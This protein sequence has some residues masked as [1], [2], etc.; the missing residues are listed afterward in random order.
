[1]STLIIN[2]DEFISYSKKNE[3]RILPKELLKYIKPS[4][5]SVDITVR[6]LLNK[7]SESNYDTILGELLS[8]DLDSITTKL[9]DLVF[10]KS[11]SEKKY[12]VLYGRLCS[13]LTGVDNFRSVLL[14]KIQEVFEKI[15]ENKLVELFMSKDQII[16]F[17]TF[18]GELYNG[19][20]ISESITM[21]IVETLVDKH[22]KIVSHPIENICVLM[23][24]IRNKFK[25]YKL[26]VKKLKV[27]K[28][29]DQ[30]SIKDKFLLMDLFDI[31]TDK[32]CK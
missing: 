21:F 3:N 29:A 16:N 20:L 15:A 9:V 17:F 30:I 5:N 8:L 14:E 13:S 6:S 18:V 31:E 19:G 1:M 11:I 2:Y 4:K 22:E 10:E 27:I 26:V 24:S 12:I 25:S 7:L 28:D 32:V 23:K